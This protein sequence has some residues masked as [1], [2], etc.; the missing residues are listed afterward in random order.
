MSSCCGWLYNKHNLCSQLCISAHLIEQVVMI[1]YSSVIWLK[2]THTFSLNQ[3]ESTT[4]SSNE[5]SPFRLDLFR[6]VLRH[7]K[8][9]SWGVHEVFLVALYAALYRHVT[10]TKVVTCL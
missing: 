3:I 10:H 4:P 8:S 6:P 5:L 7:R 1:L 2:M 9:P